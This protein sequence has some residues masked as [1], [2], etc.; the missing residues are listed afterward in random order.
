MRDLG[1]GKVGQSMK[2][3]RYF[4]A[5]VAF[6]PDG[7]QFASPVRDGVKVWDTETWREAAYLTP[8]NNVTVSQG[9]IVAFSSDGKRLVSA[10]SSV[11]VW[12]TD[13]WQEIWMPPIEL[14]LYTAG[15]GGPPPALSLDGDHLAT[16]DWDGTV[17]LWDLSPLTEPVD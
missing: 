5:G 4:I 11:Y 9:G 3:N 6:S 10:S 1:S 17:K 8:G 12:D 13:T 7:K 2:T 14:F 16:V 15:L